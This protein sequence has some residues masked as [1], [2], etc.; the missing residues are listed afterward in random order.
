MSIDLIPKQ[1]AEKSI[2]EKVFLG[3]SLVFAV[4]AVISAFLFWNMKK[5]AVWESE[6]LTKDLARE[7]TAEQI[8]LEQEIFRT[9]KTVSAFKEA[10]SR[11]QNISPAFDLLEKLVHANVYFSQANFI[12]KDNKIL[13]SGRADSFRTLGEQLSVLDNDLRIKRAD[14]T[15]LGIGRKGG[16]DF[17]MEI[18]LR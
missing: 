4:T 1:A 14:L 9:Q 3:L 15:E 17:G 16:V 5:N 10:I 7:K 18:L 6:E 2:L 12:I 11:R 13:L 8:S